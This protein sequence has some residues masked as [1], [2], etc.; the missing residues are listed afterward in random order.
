MEPTEDSETVPLGLAPTQVEPQ[1]KYINDQTPAHYP[2]SI[3]YIQPLKMEQ[4]E[5]FETSAVLKRTPGIYPKEHTQYSKPDE[6]LKL[7]KLHYSHR[8]YNRFNLIPFE[9]LA[10]VLLQT[11][12]R[13]CQRIFLLT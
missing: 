5:D 4:T 7:R 3:Y 6:S 2:H 12:S 13:R 8:I 11:A 10:F 1:H 9:V